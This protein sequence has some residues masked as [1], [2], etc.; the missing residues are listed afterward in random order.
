MYIYPPDAEVDNDLT[1]VTNNKTLEQEKRAWNQIIKDQ[2]LSKST[3]AETIFNTSHI[4]IS[5]DQ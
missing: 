5:I 2:P 1:I 3:H 4:N